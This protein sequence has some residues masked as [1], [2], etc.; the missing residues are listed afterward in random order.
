MN[1]NARSPELSPRSASSA[2]KAS[3][4]PSNDDN[5]QTVPEAQFNFNSRLIG[6]IGRVVLPSLTRL[7]VGSSPPYQA[8]RFPRERVTVKADGKACAAQTSLCGYGCDYLGVPRRAKA[9]RAF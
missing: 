1:L 2:T 6:T 3:Y 9:L 4:V 7:V 8:G 5:G